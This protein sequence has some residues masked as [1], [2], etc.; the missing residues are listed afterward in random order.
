MKTTLKF[1]RGALLSLV[2]PVLLP[3]L[4]LLG[5]NAHADDTEL[6]FGNTTV[7]QAPPLLMFTLDWRANLGANFCTDVKSAACLAKIGNQEIYDALG[8]GAQDATTKLYTDASLGSISL[9][10][11]FRA[12]FSLVFQADVMD[13]MAVGLMMNHENGCSGS[14]TVGCSNGGYILRGF[15]IFDATDSNGAKAELLNI[16]AN[17]PTAGGA[18]AHPYQ[19]KELFF[20]FYRYLTGQNV[21]RGKE[22]WDD[23][24][25]A[26]GGNP[27]G[28]PDRNL[29][30][31][32]GKTLAG[33]GPSATCSFGS[34]PTGSTRACEDY[35]TQG[36]YDLDT[37]SNVAKGG[38]RISSAVTW[39]PN[40]M[41]DP[42][43]G[44]PTVAVPTSYID[45]YDASL[46]WSCS[47]TFTI[48]MMFQVSQQED[49]LDTELGVAIASGTGDGGLNLTSRTI[50]FPGVIAALNGL[51]HASSVVGENI[52]GVQNVKSYFFVDQV[53]TTTN[54]YAQAGGTTAAIDAL[55]DPQALLAALLESLSQINDDSSSFTSV[56]V[57]VNAENRTSAL[58]NLFLALFRV[59]SQGKALW[60]GNVKRVELL[61]D[62]DGN[63]LGVV[64]A[65]NQAAFNPLNGKLNDDA[66]SIW[67]DPAAEDVVAFD[68]TKDEV[69]GRDGNSVT[70]G[71]A[72][73]KIPGFKV[74]PG[75]QGNV[76]VANSDGLRQLYL[77]PDTFNPL[78]NTGNAL[79]AL[80]AD[81]GNPLLADAAIQTLLTV[82][83]AD[84]TVNTTF[85]E[86]VLTDAG[87]AVASPLSSETT[88]VQDTAAEDATQVLLKWVRGVDVFDWDADTLRDDVRPW[89]WG[90]VLHSR[91]LSINYGALG[92]HGI[93]NQDVRLI[94]GSNDG[95]LHYVRN[96]AA[97]SPAEPTPPA[98]A[99]ALNT[100]TV[101]P[102]GEE[103]WAFMPR[104]MLS[105]VPNLLNRTN[106]VGADGHPYGVDGEPV[107]FSIDNDDDGIIERTLGNADTCAPGTDNCDKAYVY[108]GLRRGGT[109]YFALDVSFPDALPRLLWRLDENTTGFSELA[110][111]FST[112]R[113]GWVQYERDTINEFA[114]EA[115]PTPV[116][117]FGGG[118]YGGWNA[119]HTARIGKD[120]LTNTADDLK[121]NA[122]FMV[123]ARTGQLIWKAHGG[124]STV[125]VSNTEFT[126]VDMDHSIAAPVTPMD[127]DGDRLIDRLYVGDTHGQVWRV[128]LPK[129]NDTNTD[130]TY[131]TQFREDYWTVTKFADLSGSG[132]T[133]L[134]FF[135]SLGVVQA[136]DSI[137]SHDIVAG[138]TGDRAHP[139]SEGVA[140][141]GVDVVKQNWFF[142]L[143]DR[144]TVTGSP[145]TT[146]FQYSN[147]SAAGYIP[148]ITSTCLN[149]SDAGCQPAG[150]VNGYRLKLEENGEKNLSPPLI[151]AGFVTF[152]TYLPE[153]TVDEAS[154]VPLGRSRIYQ[155]Q[156][157]NGAPAPFLHPDAVEGSYTET[158]RWIDGYEGIDGGVVAVSPS[159]GINSSGTTF[160]IG[161]QKPTRYYWRERNIDTIRKP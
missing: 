153:G 64:D 42:A 115:V 159:V 19:G 9:F 62:V 147:I 131:R 111:S 75:G 152:T 13:G 21:L 154:C 157:K 43:S 78:S 41:V 119:A 97:S 140:N 20:E 65:L 63:V 148:D 54:G 158:D 138:G 134:R 55:G 116:V 133:D 155:V 107:L 11:T 109:S 3:S 123:H 68:A 50:T 104:Q 35:A 149:A 122:I 14:Q 86:D 108:F 88:G 114:G 17:I 33:N 37:D 121:G 30:F 38:P 52:D 49:S 103:T 139:Q 71:G 22:G 89:L 61:K 26:T 151:S 125:G 31:E 47:K 80:D 23:F 110:M 99:L 51:D 59:D 48:N 72:G 130:P 45:P 34:S 81:D 92:S 160:T 8:L 91:P 77:G 100:Q 36:N 16:M 124:A 142:A 126:H 127:S 27:S 39:D 161:S 87:I 18:D 129:Y 118:Y 32:F 98:P 132:A 7:N 76:G 60:A 56:T 53:N 66:L 146:V 29:D 5:A 96:T 67:A 93:Y 95:M 70:R 25:S 106:N 46:D 112:P 28:T 12:V 120:D 145:G 156:L 143:K 136:S 101:S 102:F 144:N 57:P 10:D 117:I 15:E 40:I 90:D 83:N 1:C 24:N 79:V 94:F 113:V 2:L 135:H 150:A 141:T 69:S 6:F 58:N 128:D 82:R 74:A 44:T 105:L 84:T 73:H 137:G 4:T 85:V